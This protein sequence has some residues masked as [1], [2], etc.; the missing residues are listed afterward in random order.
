MK[1]IKEVLVIA[2]HKI[3]TP[4]KWIQGALHRWDDFTKT[5]T[6]DMYAPCHCML[7]A[8]DAATPYSDLRDRAKSAL[9]LSLPGN[10]CS[11]A[12]YN[13]AQER[14]HEEVLAV[15]DKAIEEAS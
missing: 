10:Q 14:T 1:T 7:G 15:F 12:M 8:V 9:V 6:N 2:R 11:I 4:E 3:D 13:D 5:S